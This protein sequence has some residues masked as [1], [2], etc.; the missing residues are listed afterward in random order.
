MEIMS[1]FGV[2]FD[3]L[4]GLRDKNGLVVKFWIKLGLLSGMLW[5]GLVDVSISLLKVRGS[6]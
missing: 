2:M 1:G 3:G 4:V 6:K 5:L